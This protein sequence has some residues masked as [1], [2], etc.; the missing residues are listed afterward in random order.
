MPTCSACHKDFKTASGMTWHKSNSCSGKKSGGK[1]ATK[2]PSLWKDE[3]QVQAWL[4]A[5]P[6]SGESWQKEVASDVIL[7]AEPRSA[8]AVT[9]D[10]D[11]IKDKI[12]PAKSIADA[13]KVAEAAWKAGKFGQAGDPMWAATY[14]AGPKGWYRH[15]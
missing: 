13:K 9:F 10:G 2:K 8:Y 15:S 12:L 1:K 4:G 11:V 6:G 5:G 7:V 3:A 14:E